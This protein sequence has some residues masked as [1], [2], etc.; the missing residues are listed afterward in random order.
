MP[1]VLKRLVGP[2]FLAN[3]STLLYTVPASTTTV[4]RYLRVVNE[5]GAAAHFTIAI[6]TDGAG[7]RIWYQETVLDYY[8]WSGNV[9][10]AAAETLYAYASAATTLTITISGVEST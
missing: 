2:A 10:L 6:G 1:D 9:V 8:D 4:L 7:K 5:T 3:T